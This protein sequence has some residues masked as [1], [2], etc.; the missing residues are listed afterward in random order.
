MASKTY[1]VGTTLTPTNSVTDDT[2]VSPYNLLVADSITPA[3]ISSV[4]LTYETTSDPGGGWLPLVITGSYAPTQVNSSWSSS[5]DGQEIGDD[6]YIR[7]TSGPTP[8][9]LFVAD[10]QQTVTCTPPSSTT[11]VGTNYGFDIV[12]QLDGG[13]GTAS[14]DIDVV[15]VSVTYT[16][17]G[18]E[19]P[20]D[21]GADITVAVWDQANTTKVA[22]LENT[23]GRTW[24]D[25]ASDA[26]T[27]GVSLE[28]SNANADE[29]TVGRHLRF[30]FG[31]DLAFTGVIGDGDT[32]RTLA[33]DGDDAALVT[34]IRCRGIAAEWDDATVQPVNGLTGQPYADR[35]PFTWAS[36]E[37][38]ITSWS[39]CYTYLGQISRQIQ[40]DPPFHEPWYPPRGWP[41][42]DCEWMWPINRGNVYP[43]TTGLMVRDITIGVS[44]PVTHFVT[45][46][47]RSRFFIDGLEALGWTGEW[48]EQSFVDGFECT[49]EMSAG[50]HRLAIETETFDLSSLGLPA[51]GMATWCAHRPDGTGVFDSGTVIAKATAATWKGWD[52]EQ[53]GFTPAPSPGKII[54]TF[55]Q[56]AQAD[57]M[58]TGWELT[59]NSVVDSGG[60][61]WDRPVEIVARVGDTGLD[62]LRQLADVS[63]DWRAQP[64]A[65]R[66]DMWN[67]GNRGTLVSAAEITTGPSGNA[68][69]LVRTQ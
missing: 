31:D 51:R 38:P 16:V 39:N 56:E 52:V 41:T 1:A 63:V 64:A 46:D 19:T 14:A 61:P 67:K 58:L 9:G 22:D 60:Q 48:P 34:N 29:L 10:G 24:Q 7:V 30:N 21:P 23:W 50:T 45:G 57:D 2:Y 35:R 54:Q 59:F 42:M 11:L 8:V 12:A 20:T 26:G 28:T 43:V 53:K 40:L 66:L 15:E 17:A 44:G 49:V 32:E 4:T 55:L 33:G 47:Q 6:Y 69:E 5:T 18:P 65:K 68:F 62:L 37:Q 36:P 3:T 25:V 13:T 27:A